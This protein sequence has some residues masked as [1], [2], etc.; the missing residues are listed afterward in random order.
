LVKAF[1]VVFRVMQLGRWLSTF[2]D[3]I[4]SPS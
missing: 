2:R 4:L 1:S 3:N